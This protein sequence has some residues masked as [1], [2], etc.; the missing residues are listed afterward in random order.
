M[1]TSL[2]GGQ[3]CAR[4][5]AFVSRGEQKYAF[6]VG[7]SNSH[8]YFTPMK[9]FVLFFPVAEEHSAEMIVMG[10]RGLGKIKRAILGSVSDY[11]IRKAKVPVLICKWDK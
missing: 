10:A 3:V 11:V 1:C 2:P 4:S 5:T 7:V 6:V 9:C 8:P